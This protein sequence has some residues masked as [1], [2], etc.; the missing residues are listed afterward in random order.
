M[1]RLLYPNQYVESV[2]TIDYKKLYKLGYRG[3]VFDIDNTLVPHGED[4]T[5]Q[6]DELFLFV[7]SL[8]FKTL[9]LSD[10][11]KARVDSFLQNID[12]FSICLAGKPRPENFKKAVKML[13]LNQQEVVC[14]GDQMFMDVLGAN[15]AGLD[16]ILIKFIGYYTE[17]IVGRRRKLEKRILDR[18][19]KNKKYYNR[20]GEIEI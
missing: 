12:S 17:G 13:D 1:L 16:S 14:I 20:M 5:K 19:K 15:L 10:N 9:V 18:Y 3:I 6:V 11:S 7:Q 2:F 8:G 4:S